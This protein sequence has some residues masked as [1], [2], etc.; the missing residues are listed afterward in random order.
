MYLGGED[1]VDTTSPA[2]VQVHVT[3][4]APTRPLFM[5]LF[6]KVI[7]KKIFPILKTRSVSEVLFGNTYFPHPHS[8][9]FHSSSFLDPPPPPLFF[10]D[11]PIVLP[12]ISHCSPFSLWSHL[13][14]SFCSHLLSFLLLSSLFFSLF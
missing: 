12:F 11:L 2:P 5:C 13:S 14:S 10:I 1:V 9:H 7:C 4:H 6:N 3:M 8:L